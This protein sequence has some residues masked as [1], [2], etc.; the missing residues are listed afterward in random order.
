MLLARLPLGLQSHQLVGQSGLAPSSSSSSSFFLDYILLR[1]KTADW[2]EP[3][4]HVVRLFFL[5][6]F[7]FLVRVSAWPPHPDPSTLCCCCQANFS[8]CIVV[9]LER[10]TSIRRQPIQRDDIPTQGNVHDHHQQQQEEKEEEDRIDHDFSWSSD[11]LY[12]FRTAA[13]AVTRE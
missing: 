11:V 12:S 6:L 7:F 2:V 8:I 1:W 4:F 5:P 13:A 9:S 10:I 3:P